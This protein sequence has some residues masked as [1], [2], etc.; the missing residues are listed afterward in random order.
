MRLVFRVAMAHP[1]AAAYLL[2]SPN[3]FLLI[4][5]ALMHQINCAAC[6]KHASEAGQYLYV[7]E[8][9]AQSAK[10]CSKARMPELGQ[11]ELPRIARSQHPKL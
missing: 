9:C 6:L 11:R 10:L 8:D 5:E 7:A 2:T 1:Q 4:S 3:C